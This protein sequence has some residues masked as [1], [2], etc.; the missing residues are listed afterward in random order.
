MQMDYVEESKVAQV[1]GVV[2]AQLVCLVEGRTQG[3]IDESLSLWT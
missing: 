2:E 3:S 1:A